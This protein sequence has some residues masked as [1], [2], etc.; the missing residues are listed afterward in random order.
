MA[1]TLIA[2]R[3]ATVAHAG[4]FPPVLHEVSLT[5]HRGDWLAVSGANGSGKTT[6]LAALA[7]VLPLR[8]GQIERAPNLRVALLLQEPD[9]QLVASSVRQEL[10]LSVPRDVAD[11]ERRSRID[12]AIARFELGALLERNP[13][14]LSGGEKQRLALATVWLENPDVLLL[15][16]PLSYL[17]RDTRERVIAFVRELNANGV[18]IVWATPG[19]EDVALARDVIVL[20]NGRAS[21]ARERV[22]TDRAPDGRA[23]RD[24]SGWT[25]PGPASARAR[26][27][28]ESVSFSY[29]NAD[30]LRDLSLSV[31][32]GERVGI[33][34]RNGSGKSTLLLLAG[35]AIKPTRGRVVRHT[36]EHGVL[37]LPQ[38]PERLFFA[39]SVMEE[40]AFGLER[41][42]V[43]RAEAREKARAA[44]ADASLDPDGFAARSPFELSFGEMRRV[45]F[46]IA[47]AL[48]PQLLL[49]DEPASCLDEE[50]RTVLDRLVGISAQRGA[51][52]LVA[53]HEDMRARGFDRIVALGDH[54]G[55]AE[56]FNFSAVDSGDGP[57]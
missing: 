27:L 15:D 4:G 57:G 6:L 37:Y 50:G 9:N 31:S 34:G 47:F 54:P 55:A 32:P 39:E 42:G 28:L 25:E 52:V 45:A 17:D 13:H 46:A 38:S 35:G 53:S 29:D 16:E 56:V 26:L 3:D 14:R 49:L 7:G 1:P 51:G 21:G 30:V 40:V 5:I 41:R 20:Q 19:G 23:E 18:A 36:G 33:E 2:L 44:L 12:E 43:A 24:P 10:A 8:S 48:E 11:A 22:A